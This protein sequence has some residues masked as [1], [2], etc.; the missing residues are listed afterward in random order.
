[1]ASRHSAALSGQHQLPATIQP[2]QTLTQ[3]FVAKQQQQNRHSAGA[4]SSAF[5]SG[6]SPLQHLSSSSGLS[7]QQPN[8]QQ[9]QQL[10]HRSPEIS[11]VLS[12]THPQQSLV[13]AASTDKDVQM[14]TAE[15][16]LSTS[17]TEAP[18]MADVAGASPVVN[19]TPSSSEKRKRGRPKGSKTKRVGAKGETNEQLHQQEVVMTTEPS[20]TAASSPSIPHSQLPHAKP[21]QVN[22]E[23]IAGPD[24]KQADSFDSSLFPFLV[25]PPEPASGQ[26]DH[27]NSVPLGQ[28]QT[29]SPSRR[30]RSAVLS[31]EQSA[32]KLDKSPS[33][34]HLSLNTGSHEDML[35]VYEFYW[36]TMTLCA[37]F[38]QA[39][40]ELLVCT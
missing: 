18:E 14:Q 17:V 7:Q 25:P 32:K 20:T 36:N 12:T 3:S 29:R 38:F 26:L 19:A 37:D 40:T 10:S 15:D 22:D 13:E 9:Q 4:Y 28:A 2:L 30:D 39:A 21:P 16:V 27:N 11:G 34:Q 31:A 24:A 33:G 6:P 23:A 8:T 35:P 5:S 1:M